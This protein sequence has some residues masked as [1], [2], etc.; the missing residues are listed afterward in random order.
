MKKT[1]PEGAILIPDNAVKTYSGV[2]FD[3]YQWPQEMF[4]GAKKT[5][6]MLKRWDTLQIIAIK[7]GKIVIVKDEQPGRPVQTHVPGG[8]SDDSDT[9]W[10]AAAQREMLE[11]TGMSFKNWRL[12]AVEQP[13]PKIEW[14]GVFY[15]ATDFVDQIDQNLDS[16]EKIEVLRWDFNYL[17]NYVLT[18]TEPTLN[19]MIPLMNACKTLD[20]LLVLP[21]FTGIETDR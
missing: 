19:Y 8:R 18:G 9:S 2:I 14:F 12:I 5:F 15:L 11:E 20:D 4:D 13:Q 7:D 17:R 6:E 1:I 3:V 10:L 21:E 16:G